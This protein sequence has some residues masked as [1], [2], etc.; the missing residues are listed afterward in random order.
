MP[1]QDLGETEV[2][3]CGHCENRAR[4][5][6]R[7]V[8]ARIQEFSHA[9]ITWEEGDRIQV[10][11]CPACSGWTLRRLFIHTGREPDIGVVKSE[12][13]HPIETSIPSSLPESISSAYRAALKVKQINSNA[14]GV[15]LGRVLEMVAL[16]QNAPGFT[17]FERLKSLSES[18]S[19]PR[20]IAEV[21]H[22]LRKLRNIGAHA[23]LGELTP[24]EVPILDQLCRAV[25][26]YVYSLPALV[27]DA[28][29]RLQDLQGK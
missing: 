4:M 28:E 8:V 27:A 14:F 10:V 23:E 29:R 19:I 20:R 18:G 2:I 16:D 24:E 7:A 12:T 5:P 22:N 17:L 9:S 21:G 11:E 13:L 25:L 26:E 3:L 1:R 6:I 15:L